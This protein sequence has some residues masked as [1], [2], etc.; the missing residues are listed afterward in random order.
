MPANRQTR[1]QVVP[2]KL[3]AYYRVS[4]AQQQRSGLGLEAQESDV[5]RYAAACGG[6]II[7]AYTETESG[8]RADRPE[9]AKAIS[10]ARRAGSKLVI[11]KLDRLARN[12]AFISALM[13]NGFEFVCCDNPHVNRLT[14]HVL[15]AVAEE[16]ARCISA[17]TKAALA[18]AK[19]RGVRLGSKRPG[20]WNAKRKAA[21]VA[22][23]PQARER[24]ATVR[25]KNA[26]ERV[27][28]LLPVMQEQRKAGMTLQA[29][30]DALNE[31]GQPTPMGGRWVAA[32]V[33]RALRLA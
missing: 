26:R 1:E 8:K 14:L 33:Q 19:R 18:A 27:A 12:V 31:Q 6:T 21:W 13:D 32:S 4:T 9:L 30:A 17:R 10:H 15:A 16:E 24:S 22:G 25:H 28:N 29:I 5:K 3:I 23:L 20:F 7:R 2:E 11:A